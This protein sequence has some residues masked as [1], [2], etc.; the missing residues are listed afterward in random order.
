M[1]E[2]F[3]C[4]I[5]MIKSTATFQYDS[6]TI[7]HCSDEEHVSEECSDPSSKL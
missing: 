1:L 5:K 6:A 2:L 4:Q 7:I 3:S